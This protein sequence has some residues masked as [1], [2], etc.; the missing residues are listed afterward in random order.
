MHDYKLYT[1][2]VEFVSVESTTGKNLAEVKISKLQ[3]CGQGYDG[4]SNM[5]FKG[6]KARIQEI[7]PLAVYTHCVSHVLNLVLVDS[8]ENP[9]I[10]DTINTVKEVINFFKDSVQ[11]ESILKANIPK[12]ANHSRLSS[13]CET[14]WTERS[15]AIETFIELLVPVITSLERVTQ[16]Q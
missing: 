5:C 1:K 12:D 2:F 6:V 13:L 10:R 9:F 3:S 14:R 16:Q 7:Q 8:C 11:R 4:A 15:T